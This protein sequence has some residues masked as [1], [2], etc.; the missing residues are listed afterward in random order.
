[1]G[2]RNKNL[3]EDGIRSATKTKTKTSLFSSFLQSQIQQNNN[4]NGEANRMMKARN[5]PQIYSDKDNTENGGK[6]LCYKSRPGR[7]GKRERE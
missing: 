7:R 4:L 1:M 3:G 5:V 6:V 2:E